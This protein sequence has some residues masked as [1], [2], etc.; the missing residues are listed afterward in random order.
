MVMQFHQSGAASKAQTGFA[1]LF[2]T[3]F[4]GEY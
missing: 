1:A 4:S 2:H 3:A